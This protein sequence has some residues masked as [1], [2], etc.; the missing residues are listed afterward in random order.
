M[1]ST[2]PFVYT[3]EEFSEHFRHCLSSKFNNKP[4]Y[5]FRYFGDN[6]PPE[7]AGYKLERMVTAVC[8]VRKYALSFEEFTIMAEN[9]TRVL[10]KPL[11]KGLWR[12]FGALPED[13]FDQYHDPALTIRLARE[14][15]AN[16]S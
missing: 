13:C 12:R 11:M 2:P 14:E 3:F 8:H 15:L 1:K 9:G 16:E 10:Q 4:A 7:E 5:L 6:Y